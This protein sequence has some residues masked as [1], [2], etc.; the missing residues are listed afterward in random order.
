[1]LF[2]LPTLALG[3]A[4]EDGTAFGA[5]Y[6]IAAT[7]AP[8]ID[9]GSLVFTATFDSACP[10]EATSSCAGFELR[11]GACLVDEDDRDDTRVA[12]LT[13]VTHTT[14]YLSQSPSGTPPVISAQ[15]DVCWCK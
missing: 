4:I 15:P 5:P 12:C 6:S 2:T 9:A 1:M 8:L 14:S 10:A 7:P 3:C 11:V 13:N